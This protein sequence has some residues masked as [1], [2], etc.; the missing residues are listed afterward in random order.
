ME[1]DNWVKRSLKEKVQRAEKERLEKLSGDIMLILFS[2]AA[3]LYYVVAVSIF[4]PG[5]PQ[6][7]NCAFFGGSQLAECPQLDV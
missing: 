3:L 7:A 6:I 4:G 1:R 5:W 2:L